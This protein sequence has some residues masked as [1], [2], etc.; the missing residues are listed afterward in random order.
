MSPASKALT[1]RASAAADKNRFGFDAVLLEEAALLGDPDRAVGRAECAH[2][3]PNPVQAPS[4]SRKSAGECRDQ[5]S[6]VIP[7]PASSHSLI[8]V[9]TIHPIPLPLLS[10]CWQ[11]IFVDA[12]SSNGMEILSEPRGIF[13]E[14]RRVRG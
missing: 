10:W 4:V 2:A 3:D 9:S 7:C 5:K 6:P 14:P 12:D 13:L 1:P 8:A 11:S